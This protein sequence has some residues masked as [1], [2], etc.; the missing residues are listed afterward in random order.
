MADYFLAFL[1]TFLAGFA[2]F[3]AFFA[4]FFAMLHSPPSVRYQPLR[5]QAVVPTST[6]A[7]QS[8]TDEAI[9]HSTAGRQD[10]AA[11]QG[12][13]VSPDTGEA[14]VGTSDE[15]KAKEKD[16]GIEVCSAVVVIYRPT[17]M[18]RCRHNKN[19]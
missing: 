4:T 2:A 11:P 8:R 15:R 14:A 13:H 6:P 9:R 12:A 5:S 18:I 7:R 3:A 1:T 19:A 17:F 10:R 16:V